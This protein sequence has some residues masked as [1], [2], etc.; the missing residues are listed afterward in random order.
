MAGFLGLH[1][2]IDRVFIDN[3][4]KKGLRKYGTVLINEGDKVTP[5]RK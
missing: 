5:E 4:K 1:I 3:M 2:D